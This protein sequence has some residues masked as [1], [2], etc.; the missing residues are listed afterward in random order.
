MYLTNHLP[1]INMARSTTGCCARFE[2]KEWDG[3][4]FIFENK[5]FIKVNTRSFFYMPLNMGSM[6]RKVRGKI[7]SAGVDTDEF[8]MLSHELSPWKAEHY[9]AIAKDSNELDSMHISGKFIAKVFEGPYKNMREWHKQ[10]IEYVRAKGKKPI[11]TY[12][13]YTTCPK[14]SKTYGENYVVG[15]EQVED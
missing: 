7:E 3:K 9:V 5:P 4:T 8:I 11:Q 10:L 2:P 12:F 15:F 6:M 13:Y 14:C 1:A